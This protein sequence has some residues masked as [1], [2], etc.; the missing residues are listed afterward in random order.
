MSLMQFE[1]DT[2]TGVPFYRQ[3]INQVKL[4]IMT[5]TLKP[6]DKLPTIR[7]LA[8][9]LK[10]NPN[11]IAKA[12][13]EMEL[14]GIVITQVGNGTFIAKQ[15]IERNEEKRRQQL[16]EICERILAAGKQLGFSKEEIIKILQE[17]KE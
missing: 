15:K 4:G 1:I 3:I 10:I 6:G 13:N 7:S 11:T 5:G 17:Q 12:Y 14:S 8:I 2:K 9:Q 16:A